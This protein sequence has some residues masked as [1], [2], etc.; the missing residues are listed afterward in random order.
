MS[1][2]G[3]VTTSSMSREG[4]VD[5]LPPDKDRLP[6]ERPE[7]PRPRAILPRPLEAAK[8]E[9]SRR[10]DRDR[11]GEDEDALEPDSRLAVR[12]ERGPWV[13]GGGEAEEA[14]EGG[15]EESDLSE[16]GRRPK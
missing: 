4:G 15:V 5:W 9:V 14:E 13:A 6:A 11:R 16:E 8:G 10:G 2:E 1:W 12:E 7:A 3:G